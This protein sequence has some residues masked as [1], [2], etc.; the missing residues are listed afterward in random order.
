MRATAVLVQGGCIGH[1]ASHTALH[2][3]HQK[4]G[5]IKQESAMK[6]GAVTRLIGVYTYNALY[7]RRSSTSA[8]DPHSHNTK[9]QHPLLLFLVILS[10]P[11]SLVLLKHLYPEVAHDP[12]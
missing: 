11:R 9:S 5:N 3:I 12:H 7:L 10:R 4:L 6:L 2:S 8:Q 1:T